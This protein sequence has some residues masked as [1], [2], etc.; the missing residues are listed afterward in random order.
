MEIENEV[1]ENII[2]KPIK[3]DMTTQVDIKKGMSDKRLAALKAGRENY[4][5]NARLYKEMLLQKEV[6]VI[7]NEEE[8][9]IMVEP[10]HQ[11]K[12]APREKV[13]AFV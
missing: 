9:M 4:H 3:C 12:P 8:P 2:E 1:V 10:E 11:P 5:R 6:P 13:I 7:Q